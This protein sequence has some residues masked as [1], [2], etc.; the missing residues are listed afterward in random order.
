MQIVVETRDGDIWNAAFLKTLY[1]VTQDVLFLPG[2]SRESVTSLWTPNTF[3]YQATESAVEGAHARFPRT[4][5]PIALSPADVA[6]IRADAFK[7]GYRGRLFAL[8]AK[9]AMIHASVQP[10]MPDGKPTDLVAIAAELESKIRGKF[11]NEHTTIRIIGF[12]KFVGDITN[13]AGDVLTFFALAFVLS[14]IGA[15]VSIRARWRSPSSPCCA[16]WPPSSGC[17]RSSTSSA[18]RSIRSASSCRSSST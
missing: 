16:R 18:S 10:V 4:F 11:E 8:D 3:V 12:T 13:E 15:M 5:C 7:G 17:W 2:I 14:A 9:S 1:D 6:Q